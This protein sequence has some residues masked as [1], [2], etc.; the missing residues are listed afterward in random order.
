M[1]SLMD[2]LFEKTPAVEDAP[3]PSRH[4]NGQA[5]FSDE[6]EWLEPPADEYDLEEVYSI[7][8]YVDSRG[9]PTR[10]RITM[11][12]LSRGPHAPILKAVCHERR[13]V[14]AF[15]TDRIECFIDENGEVITCTDFFRNI[16]QI[17]LAVLTSKQPKENIPTALSAAREIRD[18][19]RAPLSILVA[20]AR[21]DEDFRRVEVDAICEFVG[22]VAPRVY[23]P[24]YP[25]GIPTLERLREMIGRMRPSRQSLDGYIEICET[26]CAGDEAFREEFEAA[27]HDVLWADG[28]EHPAEKSLLRELGIG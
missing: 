11:R 21:S 6:E 26:R 27:L 17:D 10:R 4:I 22:K 14:R 12:N 25:G 2:W 7:I 3:P 8:D 20:I 18:N 23:E 19:L 16:M 15:R 1:S 9:Q 5:L 24:A 28:V 13:A